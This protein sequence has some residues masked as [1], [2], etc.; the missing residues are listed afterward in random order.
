MQDDQ[1]SGKAH[2]RLISCVE[3]TSDVSRAFSSSEFVSE[4]T[5]ED[6]HRARSTSFSKGSF[7]EVNYTSWD[8]EESDWSID[9]VNSHTPVTTYEIDGQIDLRDQRRRKIKPDL[10]SLKKAVNE[11]RS[12][13]STK[14]DG[15]IASIH[16]KN[17]KK[18][19]GFQ[20]DAGTKNVLT[21]RNNA[22]KSSILD[23]LRVTHD[24]LRFVSRRVPE[25]TEFEGKSCVG[26][27][28]PTT[29]LKIPMTNI[30][31]NYSDNPASVRISLRNGSQFVIILHPD[32][33]IKAYLL[34]EG[35]LPRTTAAFQ[36]QFPLSL[37]VVPTLGP[38]E[39]REY[40]L[41]D[42]TISSSENTR[43]AHRHLRNILIRR[44]GREFDEFSQ[45]VSA[46]WPDISLDRPKVIGNGEPVEMIFFENGI[47]RE[48]FWSGFGLQVWMQ[49]VIQFMRGSDGAVLVLDEP[50]IYLHPDLQVQMMDFASQRFGQIF[51][52]THSSAIINFVNADEVLTISAKEGAAIREA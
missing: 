2:Q 39:E 16:L 35:P 13:S 26:F 25:L 20:I 9:W 18:F 50:D 37:V 8:H 29:A 27:T 22:G 30:T 42:K 32:Y 21:G 10:T 12:P 15:H 33:P 43:T 46:A 52:A 36:R 51:V 45:N 23:A 40:Y 19:R 28:L 38:V 41:T 17:F 31:W 44:T 49:M 11:G 6:F 5:A 1:K 14:S 4:P 3:N 7:A 47:P 48:I 34:T 24:V